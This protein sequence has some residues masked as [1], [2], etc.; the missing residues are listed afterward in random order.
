MKKKP[1]M[2]IVEDDPTFNQLLTA[3]FKSKLVWEVHSFITGE[4]SLK[5]LHLNPV[6]WLQDFDLPGI[7]GIEVMKKAKRDLTQTR[8]V[9]LSGQGD[10]KVAVDSLKEG[11]FDYIVK[12]S[13][14]KENALNKVDQIMHIRKLE[15]NQKSIRLGL[16]I[17]GV[18]LIISWGIFLLI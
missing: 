17:V 8:F 16:I 1:I 7:N 18:L 12:D 2:F 13:H 4:E 6:V 9:F 14:A 3:Y 5:E 10:I 11:A 15:E